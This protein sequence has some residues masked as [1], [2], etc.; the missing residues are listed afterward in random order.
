MSGSASQV[1]PTLEERGSH[2]SMNIRS[3]GTLEF[4]LHKEQ[5]RDDMEM[6]PRRQCDVRIKSIGS[7]NFAL[8]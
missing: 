7:E 3:W 6:T 2:K 4:V 1:L 5:T 8:G